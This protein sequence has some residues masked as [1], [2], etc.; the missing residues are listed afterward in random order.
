[1]H[2]NVQAELRYNSQ[3]NK[4]KKDMPAKADKVIGKQ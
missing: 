3:N 2:A 4:Q 1:M